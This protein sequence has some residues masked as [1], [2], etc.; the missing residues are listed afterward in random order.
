MSDLPYVLE[1]RYTRGHPLDMEDARRAAR[2]F[3]EMR[4]WARRQL[5]DTIADLD[6]KH[7]ALADA[8]RAYRKA[9]AEAYVQVDAKTAGERDAKVDADSAQKRYDRDLAEG[10]VKAQKERIKLAEERLAE[11]DGERASFHRLV[12]WSMRVDAFA[13]ESRSQGQFNQQRGPS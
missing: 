5:E 1:G 12:E 9:R 2:A 4:R 13:Q 3:G 10:L 8:E 6:K 11:I 7:D